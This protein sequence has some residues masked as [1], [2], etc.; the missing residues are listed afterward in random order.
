MGGGSTPTAPGGGG[1]MQQSGSPSMAP[2]GPGTPMPAR[3]EQPVIP[4]RQVAETDL[5]VL[6]SEEVERLARSV[7]LRRLGTPE[8]CA[9]VVEFLVTD[10]GDYVNGAIIPVDGGSVP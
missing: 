1:S 9:K 6:R 5:P 2:S 8:D 3:G 7:P 10:L 4:A